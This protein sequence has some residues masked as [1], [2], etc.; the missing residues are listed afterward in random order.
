M[1]TLP[2]RNP[3]AKGV[4]AFGIVGALITL[5]F[6]TA[7]AGNSD[8][9]APGSPPAVTIAGSPEEMGRAH[10][11][12]FGSEIR[13]LFTGYLTPLLLLLGTNVPDLAPS[14]RAMEPFIPERYCT[15]MHALAD[16]AGLSYDQ[17]LVANTFLD[18]K[19]VPRCSTIA[20][21]GKAT[22]DGRVMLGRNLDF[23]S[24]G[25]AQNFTRLLA[26]RPKG[27]RSFVAVGWPGLAGVLT[28][29]NRD[30]LALAVMEVYDGGSTSSGTPYIFLFRQI[31]EEC[32]TTKEAI[33][34][35]RKS[36]ITTSNNL[37]L[38]DKSG[39]IAVA[40]IG[41]KEVFVREPTEDAV[42]SCNHFQR[43]TPNVMPWYGRYRTLQKF[44]RERHGTIDVPAIESVLGD[45]SQGMLT[46][47]SMVILPETLEIYLACDTVP[48]TKGHYVRVSLASM[49]R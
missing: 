3:R 13:L 1:T 10:A 17:V 15:E 35:L 24:L 48:A 6:V 4:A 43:D 26:Y 42:Y 41:P 45:V 23:P 36:R 39:A 18:L 29:V 32:G 19:E 40:E 34:L 28:G 37:I 5:L 16:A 9:S 44:A 30:G 33:A 8:S 46:L 2:S 25:V 22:R 47:Q 27:Y 38:A 20:V 12:A 7:L 21:R 14:A 49:L 11:T 31:L